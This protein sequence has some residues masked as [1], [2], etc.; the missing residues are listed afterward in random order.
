MNQNID[1][2]F[3]EQL[4]EIR[5]L[6]CSLQ[7]M[8]YKFSI[9]NSTITHVVA[10][11]EA[12]IIIAMKF[13]FRSVIE[14]LETEM[15]QLIIDYHNLWERNA[16]DLR[17]INVQYDKILLR[18]N[19]IIELLKTN[20]SKMHMLNERLQAV[21]LWKR[22]VAQQCSEI[23][24]KI[25]EIKID[26]S[27]EKVDLIMAESDNIVNLNAEPEQE[28]STLSPAEEYEELENKILYYDQEIEKCI[29]SKDLLEKKRAEIV[30]KKAAIES[31]LADKMNEYVLFL[32]LQK[33]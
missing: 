32:F 31:S 19:H 14:N 6:L 16:T 24:K 3:F 18:T 2:E 25:T 30:D 13:D 15:H 28:K 10:E 26:L 27:E 17:T 11:V 5:Q 7:I 33:D 9:D 4:E 29:R 21:N 23:V 8:D 20:K 1:Q 12:R 22:S